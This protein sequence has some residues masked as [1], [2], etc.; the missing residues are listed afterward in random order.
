MDY[1]TDTEIARAAGVSR[2]VLEL[3][4]RKSL[5]RSVYEEVLRL[6]MNH[7]CTLLIET[8]LSVSQVAEALDYEEIK[9][10]SRGFRKVV[11][12]SPSVYRKK[13]SIRC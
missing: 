7:A 5:D 10:F 8:N 1:K 6:R 11:G 4:F 2:R 13:N 3:H 9:Y 12:M